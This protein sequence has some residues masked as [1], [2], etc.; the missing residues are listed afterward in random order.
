MPRRRRQREDAMGIVFRDLL[1]LLALLMLTLT[2]LII[3]LIRIPKES[4]RIEKAV[5]DMLAEIVWNPESRA[6]IDIW[7]E[8]PDGEKVGYLQPDGRL[9]NLVR[10]DMGR[11]QDFSGLN[12]EFLFSRGIPDGRYRFSLVYY[13]DNGQGGRPET[14][15][16]SIRYRRGR[17][18]HVIHEARIVLSYPGQEKAVVAFRMKDGRPVPGSRDFAP[19]RI[20]YPL[21]RETG[22]VGPPGKGG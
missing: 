19:F 3:P 1:L 9:F 8:G 18:V 21:L 5:G 13:S 16:V 2:V 6:D 14:V 22:T 15:R 7:V 4:R 10:D 11:D 17:T 20:F 12:Y